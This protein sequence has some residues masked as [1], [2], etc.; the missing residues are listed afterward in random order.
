MKYVYLEHLGVLWQ[1]LKV[2]LGNPLIVFSGKCQTKIISSFLYSTETYIVNKA[3]VVETPIRV[4][5]LE[6]LTEIGALYCRAGD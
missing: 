2:L 4:Y 3:A 6:I 1:L 5:M